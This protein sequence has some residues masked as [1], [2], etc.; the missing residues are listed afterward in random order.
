MFSFSRISFNSI[1]F[2]VAGV[3]LATLALSAK[4]ARA[5][6]ETALDPK[7]FKKFTLQEIYPISHNTRRYRFGLEHEDQK[8]GLNVASC[9]VVKAPIGENGKDVIRPYTPVSDTE[10]KGFF[11]L[12]VKSYPNGVMSKHFGSLNPGDALEFKGPFPKIEYKPNMKK[13]IGMIAGGSGITPMYQVIGKILQN[14]NDKTQISLIY[15]N[16]S[17]NDILLKQELDTLA[18]RHR[19]RFKVHY[20]IDKAT[21]YWKGDTGFV[22]ENLVSKYL[23]TPDENN[24]IYVCGPPSMMKW[25]SGEKAPD[26]SQGELTGLLK[27]MGYKE[28]HVFKF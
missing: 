15:A 5:K 25:I 6:D 23:P 14:P 2:G 19:D 22:T 11:D 20:T 9:L 10:D 12:V 13:K 17:E 26:F 7:N 21:K 28:S 8:L 27:K 16:L 24:A 4:F 18:R 1:R 3:A